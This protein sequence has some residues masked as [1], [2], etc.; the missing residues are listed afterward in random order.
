MVTRSL[1]GYETQRKKG[2]VTVQTGFVLNFHPV[3]RVE[4]RGT[5]DRV[6]GKET[7]KRTQ[8]LKGGRVVCPTWR[9]T[10]YVRS[11]GVELV[12]STNITTEV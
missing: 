11:R 5:R 12:L 4:G 2:F 3:L 1:Q 8:N 9:T 7:V 10:G 6:K